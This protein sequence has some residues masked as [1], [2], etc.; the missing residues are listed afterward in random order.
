MEKTTIYK[1]ILAGAALLL[2]L[3]GV[4]CLGR[5]AGRKDVRPSLPAPG[6]VIADTSL[7]IHIEKP[8]IPAPAALQALPSIREEL[9]LSDSPGDSVAVDVPLETVTYQ[10][11]GW[12]AVV[13]GHHAS[14]DSL[15]FQWKEVTVTR[16]V[17]PAW[18]LDAFA[19]VEALPP[20]A[21]ASAGLSFTYATSPRL[22]FESR[23]GVAAVWNSDGFAAA[24]CVSAGI[25]ITL[26]ER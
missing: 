4:Y 21:V 24:P 25:R 2:A 20:L 6:H 8:V 3:A 14:L 22:S 17:R 23:A 9:P 26:A 13:S 7:T 5:A 19:T 11:D 12:A 15:S 16:T 18:S 10:G 1:H